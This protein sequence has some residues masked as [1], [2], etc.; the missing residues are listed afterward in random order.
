[1]ETK[2]ER[3]AT[4]LDAGELGGTSGGVLVLVDGCF[5]LQQIQTQ[6]ATP[7]SF[8][9]LRHGRSETVHVVATVTVITEK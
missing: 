9:R 7:T 1:M 3:R 2:V 4:A 8:R 5:L 6:V